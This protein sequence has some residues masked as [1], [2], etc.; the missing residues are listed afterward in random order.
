MADHFKIPAVIRRLKKE[1]DQ[2]KNEPPVG[3]HA[4]SVSENYETWKATILG[5]EGTPYENGLF[6]LKMEIHEE[7]PFKPPKVWFTT[8]IYH[9][10]VDS[11][12]W[13]SLDIL[14]DG[15]SPA[16]KISKI[17]STVRSLLVD[18]DPDWAVGGEVYAAFT[19]NRSQYDDTAKEWTQ[20]HAMD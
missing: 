15:W 8:K 11:D 10:N 16:L 9:V 17:L 12:G 13:I 4:E 14:N 3:C 5:P 19:K 1:E 6:Y 18:P 20:K 2:I 7:Y